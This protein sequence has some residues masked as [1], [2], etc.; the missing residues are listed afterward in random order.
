M[1]KSIYVQRLIDQLMYTE[2]QVSFSK[3]G[4]CA[5]VVTQLFSST[6]M[7]FLEKFG[8]PGALNFNFSQKPPSTL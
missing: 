8:N 6:Q 1:F 4:E 2:M 5:K 7:L 3:K